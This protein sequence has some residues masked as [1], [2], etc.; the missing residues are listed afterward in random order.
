MSYDPGGRS[1]RLQRERAS[2][3]LRACMVVIFPLLRGEYELG[4]RVLGYGTPYSSLRQ[5][6]EHT[7]CDAERVSCQG[8]VTA[9]TRKV[10]PPLLG[11][12]L[13]CL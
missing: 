10:T 8:P 13:L 12:L 2:A 4:F 6:E 1:P 11:N 7:Y 9:A 3:Y 5:A